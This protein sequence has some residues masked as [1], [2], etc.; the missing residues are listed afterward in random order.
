MKITIQVNDKFH[1]NSRVYGQLDSGEFVSDEGVL[2]PNIDAI[3][4]MHT[5]YDREYGEYLRFHY[6]GK[7]YEI[8]D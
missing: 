7:G 1:L 8:E 5:G 4:E 6:N 3:L 2:F